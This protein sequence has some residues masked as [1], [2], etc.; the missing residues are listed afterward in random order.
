MKKKSSTPFPGK[1][2]LAS[3]WVPFSPACV[4][5]SQSPAAT[6][7]SANWRHNETLWNSLVSW[8]Q[9]PISWEFKVQRHV[10]WI[11]GKGMEMIE[12]TKNWFHRNTARNPEMAISDRRME[13]WSFWSHGGG[14]VLH[15]TRA[16]NINP[17]SGIVTIVTHQNLWR[18]PSFRAH[19]N[20]AAFRHSNA[21]NC[22]RWQVNSENWKEIYLPGPPKSSMSFHQSFQLLSWTFRCGSLS[23]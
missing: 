11:K 10:L 23:G 21:C 18:K 2:C 16:A 5:I 8:C 14:S 9:R 19:L 3:L 17:G 1:S 13:I 20:K 6:E 12:L 4:A 15:P 22:D 7:A